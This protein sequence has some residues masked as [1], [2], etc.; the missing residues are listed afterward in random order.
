MLVVLPAEHAPPPEDAALP[1]RSDTK[2]IA[3]AGIKVSEA[4]VRN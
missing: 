3:S 2:G 1:S 4:A